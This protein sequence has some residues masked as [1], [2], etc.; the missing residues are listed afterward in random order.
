MTDLPQ[1]L[2][3]RSIPLRQNPPGSQCGIDRDVIENV[4]HSF[5]DAIR[6]DEVLGPIFEARIAPAR[7]PTHLGVM[8]DFWSS[9]LLMTGA[10]KGKPVPA[11]RPMQLEDQHFLRWLAIFRGV[12]TRICTPEGAQL[13]M[14]R[15]IRIA[16]SLRMASAEP[17][18]RGRPPVLVA[19]LKLEV[20]A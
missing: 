15:A 10:Y 17:I 9:V 8:V 11:H 14:D 19:P 2:A 13:F 3:S 1:A 4:V 18:A 7:W 20:E 12:V 16:D 5:Y 6:A